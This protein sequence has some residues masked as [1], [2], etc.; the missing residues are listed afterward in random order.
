MRFFTKVLLTAVLV[1]AAQTAKADLYLEPYIGYGMGTA[2]IQQSAGKDSHYLTSTVIGGRV[3]LGLPIVFLGVDYS[4]GTGTSTVKDNGTGSAAGGDAT[5]TQLFA[6]VGAH[7]PLLRAYAG[8]GLINDLKLKNSNGEST[9][10]GSAIKLGVGYSGLPFVAINFEMIT[11][12]FNK[13]SSSAGEFDIQSGGLIEKA[14][15]TTYMV[16]VSLPLSF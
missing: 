3:G 2:E 16:N 1:L 15:A 14:S 5:S 7:I 12:T 10:K 4:L 6:V 8:Y 11:S 9:L 13:I